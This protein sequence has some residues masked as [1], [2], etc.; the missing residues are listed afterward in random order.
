LD[1]KQASLDFYN[2]QNQDQGDKDIGVCVSR[3]QA[4]HTLVGEDA[5]LKNQ[6]LQ[7]TIVPGDNLLVWRYP[8]KDVIQA[9]PAETQETLL[10]QIKE[11]YLFINQSAYELQQ[12]A[13]NSGSHK[14]KIEQNHEVSKHT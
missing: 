3:L 1:T 14:F 5:A 4:G 8:A 12:L 6:V 7:Y 9:W 10:K 11:K 2:N 13:I